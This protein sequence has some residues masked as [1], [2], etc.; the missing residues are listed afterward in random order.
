[1]FSLFLV[2]MDLK[3]TGKCR[4]HLSNRIPYGEI[5]TFGLEKGNKLNQLFNEKYWACYV[6]IYFIL[7]LIISLYRLQ[8]LWETG[9][10]T[11]WLRKNYR[12]LNLDKCLAKSKESAAQKPIKLVDLTSA[13]LILGV[14]I[15]VSIFTFL[16]ELVYF[17]FC[18]RR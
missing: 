15:S 8:Y 12:Q 18:Q 2:N 3:K 17:K 11:Y 13:F 7:Q 10:L 5:Y 1:M 4:L 16:L 9:L 14:G 6:C